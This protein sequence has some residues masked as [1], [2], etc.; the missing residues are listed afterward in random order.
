M[1]HNS[2]RNINRFLPG[3]FFLPNFPR[4]CP[5]DERSIFK[6]P[7][8]AAGVLR[9]KA[10]YTTVMKR[11]AIQTIVL[12]LLVA[13]VSAAAY[14]LW[15]AHVIELPSVAIRSVGRVSGLLSTGSSTV[16]L[17]VAFHRQEHSLSC[18]IATLKMALALYG[19][20]VSE[21]EL[22]NA[23]P[24]DPTP[25]GGGIWGDPNKG[26]VGDIDG[27]MLVDGYGVYWDPIAKVGMKYKRT[28]VL[29]NS[30]AAAVAA[31]I[32]AGR[33]V[34][35][36]GYFGRYKAYSWTSSS[37]T[38]VRAVNGEHT[39]IVTGFSGPVSA[40][41]SFTIIDPIY[42]PAQWSTAKFVENWTSLGQHGVVVYPEPRWVRV[43]DN[44]RVWEISE[45]GTTRHWVR[46]P[47]ILYAR[48]GSMDLVLAIDNAQIVRYRIGNEIAK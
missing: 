17:P 2:W 3:G 43:K 30:N 4:V 27:R 37:G 5:K 8:V 12:L 38:P 13:G 46:S 11:L 10:W 32:A 16:E 35:V 14:G 24:F 29:R 6:E 34:I 40:P 20:E 18:E 42:G 15:L 48:G 23:L 19:T 41:T 26:F 45:D 44:P 39:R 47:A 28:S 36:W 25:K 33:P 7:S 31:H 22:I 1:L 21:T 9:L